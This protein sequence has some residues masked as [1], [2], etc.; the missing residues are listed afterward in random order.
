ML[1]MRNNH[2]DLVDSVWCLA[3]SLTSI[4]G[5]LWYWDMTLPIQGL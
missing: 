5:W 4:G 2:T 3:F 1:A